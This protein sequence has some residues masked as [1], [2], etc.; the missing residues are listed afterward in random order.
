[1]RLEVLF[2]DAVVHVHD[3][4][5]GP[6]RLGRAPV[7]DVVLHDGDVSGHHA[8]VWIEGGRLWF[9][10]LGSTNGSWLDDARIEGRRALDLG[11][12]VRLGRTAR[13]RVASQSGPVLAPLVLERTD[14]ELSW[15]VSGERFDLPVDADAV[16]LRDETG[17]IWLAVDGMEQHR[18]DL[19]TPFQAG[20]HTFVLRAITDAVPD[21]A[22]AV[23]I[24]TGARVEV[25]LAEP[26]AIVHGPGD[27]RCTLRSE[28]RV[29]LLYAL[30][31]RWQEDPVG[32]GRGWMDD[33]DVAVAIWGRS[34]R[35]R[36][37]N[38]LNVLVHR[39]RDALDR[40][41]LDRWIIEKRP[42]CIRLKAMAVS[43]E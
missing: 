7:N 26:V 43:V 13:L 29:A 34:W 14:L 28:H 31:R 42:G 30:G 18:V 27:L 21:T 25:R 41:G 19:D 11:Q 10:D 35:D 6:V 23:G 1:M 17:E 20:G 33:E 2:A 40:C 38:S 24:A 8:V 37:P 22:R 32:P 12:V 3:V 15:G 16:L 9:E 5:H 4:G 39:T 36:G